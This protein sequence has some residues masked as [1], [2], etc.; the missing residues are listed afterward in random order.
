[1]TPEP[2]PWGS[3]PQRGAARPGHTMSSPFDFPQR[4][5][6]RSHGI[7]ETLWHQSNIPRGRTI[8]PARRSPRRHGRCPAAGPAPG[9]PRCRPGPRPPAR[10]AAPAGSSAQHLKPRLPDGCR[11]ET[12]T[13]GTPDPPPPGRRAEAAAGR[14]PSLLQCRHDP[15]APAPARPANAP[16]PP[17]PPPAAHPP[18]RQEQAAAC[19]RS[20]PGPGPAAPGPARRHGAEPPRTAPAATAPPPPADRAAAPRR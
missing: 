5:D 16:P 1:M 15:A 12:P 18:P 13:T 8:T 11:S 19:G 9:F 3:S 7:C 10:P 20:R 4:P 17:A 2:T 6:D 14:A